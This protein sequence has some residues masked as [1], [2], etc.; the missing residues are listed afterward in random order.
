MHHR[1]CMHAAIMLW[2]NQFERKGCSVEYCRA[3]D[4]IFGVTFSSENVFVLNV[5]VTLSC[6]WCDGR[7]SALI[8]RPRHRCTLSTT[9]TTAGLYETKY[10][11]LLVDT[12]HAASI[13]TGVLHLVVVVVVVVVEVVVEVVV[14]VVVIIVIV[15]VVIKSEEL[16]KKRCKK[17]SV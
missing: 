12:V 8:A 10:A 7:R 9:A 13:Q 17:K 5:V 15:V 1:R 3:R 6:T 11:Q 4:T 2:C 16:E 14:V